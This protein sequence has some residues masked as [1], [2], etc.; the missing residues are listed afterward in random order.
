MKIKSQQLLNS[1]FNNNALSSHTLLSI[2]TLTI[3]LLATY[4]LTHS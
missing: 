4:A 1:I 3:E 2:E